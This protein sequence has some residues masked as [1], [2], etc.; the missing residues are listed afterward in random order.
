MLLLNISFENY[1]YTEVIEPFDVFCIDNV[2]GML[3]QRHLKV[4]KNNL[5]LL[6]SYFI[7]H[8]ALYTI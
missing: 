7:K 2:Q 5:L 6:K 8:T 3:D 1:L 4:I